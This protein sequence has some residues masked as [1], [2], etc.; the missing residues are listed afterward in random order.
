MYYILQV[1]RFRAR[2]TTE[3]QY[4]TSLAFQ[5]T[6]L[7][8]SLLVYCCEGKVF[9][10]RA[11]LILCQNPLGSISPWPCYHTFLLPSYV[12]KYRLHTEMQ[13]STRFTLP[14]ATGPRWCKKRRDRTE[15]CNQ[16]VPWSICYSYAMATLPEG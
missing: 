9:N 4:F 1:H 12:Y 7:I 15:V 2:Q 8:Y 16:L 6:A 10:Y 14:R 5:V 11:C 13:V 3:M